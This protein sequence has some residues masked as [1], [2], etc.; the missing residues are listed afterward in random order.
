MKWFKHFT[1]ARDSKKLTKIRIRY[2]AEGYAIYWYCLELI[3]GDIGTTET[4]NF[5]LKHDAEVIGHNLKIDQPKVEEIMNY[6]VDLKLFDNSN[7]VITCLRLAKYLDKKTTRN[8][9]IH[10]IID[11]YH[12]LSPSTSDL[13][14]QGTNKVK[15]EVKTGRFVPPT[16]EDVQKYIKDKSYSVDAER[17][18]DF[19]ESKGWMIG[20]NKMKDWK[21]AVRSARSWCIQDNNN[22]QPDDRRIL[23]A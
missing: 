4:I 11:S 3:A 19:Y 12:K 10:K 16:I 22:Q 14:R 23:N 7:G 2:G 18:M 21:A 17:F 9:T 20:K 1:N 5:E 6:M 8:K 15:T 13:S